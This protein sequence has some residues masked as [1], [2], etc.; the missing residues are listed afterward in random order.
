[1]FVSVSKQITPVIQVAE[2]TA[3]PT[4]LSS[5]SLSVIP[6][7]PASLTM[8]NRKKSFLRLNS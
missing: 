2:I 5:P 1:M 6:L 7:G 8:V 4:L 3:H